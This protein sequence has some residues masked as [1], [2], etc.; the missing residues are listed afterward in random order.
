MSEVSHQEGPNVSRETNKPSPPAPQLNKRSSV[1]IYLAVLFGAAFLM[2]LLAY[3]IQQRNSEA[4]ISGLQ[5]SWNLSREELMEE[6]Q[7]LEEENATLKDIVDTMTTERDKL[8]EENN[9]LTKQLESERCSAE[10]WK[11]RADVLSSFAFLEQA[12]RDKDYEI[13]AR[14]VRGLCQ[15][16]INLDLGMVNTDGSMRFDAEERLKEVIPLLERQGALAPEE[17]TLP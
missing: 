5:S 6:N 14:C 2:L 11:D 9:D 10:A 7:R 12:L 16:G 13:A 15:E 3:F 1:Y 4:T 8:Q 17:I